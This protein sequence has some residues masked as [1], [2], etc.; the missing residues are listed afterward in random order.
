MTFC[1]SCE[2]QKNEKA[3]S[4]V[5]AAVKAEQVPDDASY[6]HV[7]VNGNEQELVNLYYK[8]DN[9][10][11]RNVA[12]AVGIK[13]DGFDMTQITEFIPASALK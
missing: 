8:A 10:K 2:D 1:G 7:V 6:W 13:V 3:E 9:G 4:V 5:V 11:W 12:I